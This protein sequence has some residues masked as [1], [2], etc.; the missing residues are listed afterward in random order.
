MHVLGFLIFGFCLIAAKQPTN[1]R[2]SKAAAT[3]KGHSI[4]DR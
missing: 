1:E 3:T 2:M 4:N